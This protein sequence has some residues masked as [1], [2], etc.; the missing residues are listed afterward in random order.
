M[1]ESKVVRPSRATRPGCPGFRRN[2]QQLRGDGVAPDTR[3]ISAALA[4]MV[5]LLPVFEGGSEIEHLDGAVQSAL[6]LIAPTDGLPLY[7]QKGPVSGTVDA[8]KQLGGFLHEKGRTETGWR[9]IAAA[10]RLRWLHH[11]HGKPSRPDQFEL[12]EIWIEFG[13]EA[14]KNGETEKARRAYSAAESLG[15]SLRERPELL[16]KKEKAKFD[17]LLERLA[18]RWS[19]MKKAERERTILENDR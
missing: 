11:H 3:A 10:I 5:D 15:H 17:V 13:D 14:E 18:D 2:V 8:L 19:K 1:R 12:I 16:W 4:E 6:D 9:A 7:L